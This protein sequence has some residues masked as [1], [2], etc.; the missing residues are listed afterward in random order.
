M[1]GCEFASIYRALG[2]GVTLVEQRGRLLPD[3]DAIVGE[4][5]QEDLLANG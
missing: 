1:L 3:W 5:V 2:C 4:L